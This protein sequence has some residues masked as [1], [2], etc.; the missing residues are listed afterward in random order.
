MPR[1]G[2]ERQVWGGRGDLQW[3]ESHGKRPT[4]P[5][6]TGGWAGVWGDDTAQDEIRECY[7]Y[8]G[9]LLGR[10]GT[11]KSLMEV[12][13]EHGLEAPSV[14]RFPPTEVGER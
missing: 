9:C 7:R 11:G 14:V 5:G 13:E 12:P 8:S 3:P 1:A 4:F 6:R 2:E 10:K